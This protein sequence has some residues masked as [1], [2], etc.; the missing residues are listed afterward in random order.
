MQDELL[1]PCMSWCA[2]RCVHMAL[3]PT[4]L[5]IDADRPFSLVVGILRLSKTHPSESLS[6]EGFIPPPRFALP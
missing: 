5:T 6:R 2:A 1:T 4:F 3:H